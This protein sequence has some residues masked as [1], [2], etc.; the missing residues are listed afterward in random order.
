MAELI[1]RYHAEGIVQQIWCGMVYSDD[2]DGAL[3]KGVSC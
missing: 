2:F 3:F 1:D